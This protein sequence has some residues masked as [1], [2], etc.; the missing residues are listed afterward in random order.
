MWE[1]VATALLR[2]VTTVAHTI[3]AGL[4]G[5]WW[6]NIGI[7]II[8]RD[9]LLHDALASIDDEDVAGELRTRLVCLGSTVKSDTRIVGS[10]RKEHRGNFPL[11]TLFVFVLPWSNSWAYKIAGFF[12]LSWLPYIPHLHAPGPGGLRCVED[13]GWIEM[14]QMVWNWK[15]EELKPQWAKLR[16]YL[17]RKI[18]R[19]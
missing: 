13:R 19:T 1:A 6:W 7:D 18:A 12:S 2:S 16:E 14:V 15:K 8:I 3:N 9:A 5:G 4:R 17:R 11:R 10:L